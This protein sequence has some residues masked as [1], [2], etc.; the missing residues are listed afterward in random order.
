MDPLK[1]SDTLTDFEELLKLGCSDLD[2]H[3][4]LVFGHQIGQ[5]LLSLDA[6]N[7]SLAAL[8]L[9]FH[10]FAAITNLDLEALLIE[11]CLEHSIV[12]H[13]V[14]LIQVALKLYILLHQ[15][16]IHLESLDFLKHRADIF[17]NEF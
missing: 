14:P 3:W 16:Q 5:L 13:D 15:I 6:L 10:D 8:E 7:R 2:H 17:H 9:A 1:Y 4:N 12:F 11:D